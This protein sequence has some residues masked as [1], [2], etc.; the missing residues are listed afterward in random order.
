MF[1]IAISQK[2]KY[3]SLAAGRVLI[4]SILMEVFFSFCFL[5]MYWHAGGYALDET[6]EAGA[7]SWTAVALPTL[8]SMFFIY[9]LFE[10]KRAP[11]DHT[12][13]ESELVAGHQ[14]ELGGRALL[15]L[16]LCEYVHLY[17]CL[18][19]IL[20]LCLGGAD[21]TALSGVAPFFTD[22]TY[23]LPLGFAAA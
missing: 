13:A 11:F 3:A 18:F 16:F 23:R 9:T 10:A 7:H 8:A 17:F 22:L 6:S 20:T 15:F 5:F 12:E 1:H 2:S 19:L 21:V 14:V 4:I